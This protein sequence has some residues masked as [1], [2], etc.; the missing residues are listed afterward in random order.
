MSTPLLTTK[1]HVPAVRSELVQRPRL[2]GRL[3]AGLDR[4]LTL[5][6]A[7]AGFG[8]TTLLCEWI[9]GRDPLP[10]VA[11]LSLDE[12]DN[13]AARF[14]TYVTTALQTTHPGIG[15]ETLQMLQAPQLSSAPA[16]LTPLL[17]AI[18]ALSQPILLV[19]DDYHLIANQAIHEA[20]AFVLEHQPPNLH[21]ALSTR[22]DPPLPTYR[23]RARGQLVE[24]RS[25]DLRFT[26][27]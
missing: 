27:E 26:P 13:D 22:A 1:L 7:P 24:L 6:S 14:W 11:W 18:A 8:K 20:L 10:R 19:L 15:Q 3:D 4:K 16:V 12:D 5:L 9:T 17:N 21:L 2:L 23:L 25:G